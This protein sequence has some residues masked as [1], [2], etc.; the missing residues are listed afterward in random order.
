MPVSEGLTDADHDLEHGRRSGE[1][2][3][4]GHTRPDL[5][6]IRDRKT[7]GGRIG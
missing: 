1:V 7:S 3:R 6:L 5:R 4:F 2:D